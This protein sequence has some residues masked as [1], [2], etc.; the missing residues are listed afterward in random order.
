MSTKSPAS[1]CNGALIALNHARHVI[2][3]S[4]LKPIVQALVISIVRYRM[5]VYGTCGETQLYRVQKI[6]N[7]CDDDL[8]F[9]AQQ[10]GTGLFGAQFWTF[11]RVSY[12]EKESTTWTIAEC[13]KR[14]YDHISDVYRDMSWLTAS[15]LALYHCM[16]SVHCVLVTGRPEAIADTFGQTARLRHAHD[17]RRSSEITLPRIR[18]P[19]RG[20]PPQTVLRSC[21]S[22]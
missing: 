13:G 7:F 22:V 12:V 5:S 10:L 15:A 21:A 19:S 14:K 8:G 17:T 9:R 11:V 18:I 1:K 6:L 16:C 2:P 20:G 3:R 4:V